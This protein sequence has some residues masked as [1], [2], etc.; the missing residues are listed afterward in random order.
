LGSLR[1]PIGAALKKTILPDFI[2]IEQML[3]DQFRDSLKRV[4]HLLKDL[5]G[6]EISSSFK[7]QV[8][9]KDF[10]VS[11]FGKSIAKLRTT[12]SYSEILPSFLESFF[13][14][15]W[16]NQSVS[17]E[18]EQKNVLTRDIDALLD[19]SESENLALDQI[20]K[21]I[22]RILRSH[23][24]VESASIFGIYDGFT[25]E[26]LAGIGGIDQDNWKLSFESAAGVAATTRKI[27]HSENPAIDPSFSLKK[28]LKSPRNLL[29]VPLIHGS[30]LVGVMN[31]SNRIGGEFTATDF[32]LVERF[33]NLTA[34][35]LQKDFLK[36]RMQ[37]FE[38]TS[39][40]LGKYLSSKVVKNVK[41]LN[42]LNLGGEE[43]YVVCLFSDI[44]GYT[45]IS[46]G[47]KAPQLVNLL[48]FYFEKMHAIIEKHEGTLDKIVGDLIMTVWNIPM[49]Q[50]D[51]EFLAIKTALEMQKE[52]IRVVAPEW[53]KNGVEKVG[54]GI[55]VNAGAALV[56]NLGSSRFMNYTVVGDAVNT[57]QRLEAKARAGEIWVSESI[58]EKVSGRIEKPLRKENGIHLKG[59]EQP[60]D[61]YVYRPLSY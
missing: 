29:C 59:K 50:P 10:E 16:E 12:D 7:E 32:K 43:K 6:K 14:T 24:W 4:P 17:A 18:L 21:N 33:S 54:M 23:I 26:G 34:H 48:N 30:T 5:S 8:S 60:I 36:K 22:L 11:M 9:E 53:A 40:H 3:T 44:R 27:F 56:G 37:T 35:V 20:L 42:Q 13:L 25:L 61:A 58:F 1:Y 45:S 2:D 51:P 49:D 41:S 39:D 15:I 19:L 28:E 47:I 52:M 57:A 46:E 55:G 31:L 38:K